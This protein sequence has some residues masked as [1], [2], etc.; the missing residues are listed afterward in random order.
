MKMA[1][2]NLESPVGIPEHTIM[3]DY[4]K[5]FDTFEFNKAMDYIWE[6]ISVL[7]GIIQKTEPFK[8]VKSDKEKGVEIIKD[9]AV[10]L[11]EIGRLLNP[12]LPETS[13]LIKEAVKANKMLSEPLFMRK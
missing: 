7:D 11:Y 3:D 8:L 6:E 5:F 9:L 4:F 10:K 12:V 1:E 2:D 13:K